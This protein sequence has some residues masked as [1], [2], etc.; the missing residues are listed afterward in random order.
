[1]PCNCDHMEPSEWERES[2]K[3]AKLLVYVIK[4][5]DGLTA[6]IDV[7]KAADNIYGETSKVHA[8][9]ADLCVMLHGLDDEAEE[10]IVYNGRCK[11]SRMLAEWWENHYEQEKAKD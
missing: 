2:Q 10:R 7:V 9:T 3:V 8:W 6:P 11:T 1:M 5:R 4:E